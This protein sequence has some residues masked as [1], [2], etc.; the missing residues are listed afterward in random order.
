MVWIPAFVYTGI[1]HK[2]LLNKMFA[3]WVAFFMLHMGIITMTTHMDG[4]LEITYR[5]APTSKM[6]VGGV[7]G[8][9]ETK[10]TNA[11]ALNQKI[12]T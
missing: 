1:T 9:S 5:V 8:L 7:L 10:T 6:Q 4:K 12:N 2:H 11:V 3:E